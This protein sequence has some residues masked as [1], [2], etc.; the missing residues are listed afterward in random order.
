MYLVAQ[1]LMAVQRLAYNLLFAWLL[2]GIYLHF[3]CTMNKQTWEC[4]DRVDGQNP[5]E[6]LPLKG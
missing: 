3:T 5:V 1:A 2:S 6:L 4:R